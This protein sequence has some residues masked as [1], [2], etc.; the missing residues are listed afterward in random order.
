MC[1]GHDHDHD[2]GHRQHGQHG[3]GDHGDHGD[4]GHVLESYAHVQGGPPVLDIGG[5]VGALA[6]TLDA[7]RAG[8]ELFVRSDGEL[9]V[10]THTGVWHRNVAGGAVT[11]AV[12]AELAAGTYVVLDHGGDDVARVEVR[13]G[14]LATLDLR[15]LVDAT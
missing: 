8:T 14:E 5:D 2:H 11:A 3:H 15:T 7:S 13:G 6:V 12:F 10:T 9:A 4:H 1:D